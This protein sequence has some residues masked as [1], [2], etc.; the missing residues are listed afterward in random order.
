MMQT[1]TCTG[2]GV[3][4]R[5]RLVQQSPQL[6]SV[7]QAKLLDVAKAES[8]DATERHLLAPRSGRFVSAFML[9]STSN[10]RAIR[11]SVAST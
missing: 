5:D 1:L 2:F 11:D 9:A 8:K 3:A 7:G 4:G 10:R 6:P